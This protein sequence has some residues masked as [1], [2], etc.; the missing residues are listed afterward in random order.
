VALLLLVAGALFALLYV[1]NAA[2]RTIRR[3]E[4]IGF[5]DTLLAFLTTLILLAALVANALED[6]GLPFVEQGVV[7]IALV[8]LL[9][10]LLIAI[11][12]LR[13]PQRLRQS[14]GVFGM[15]AALLVLLSTLTVPLVSTYFELSVEIGIATPTRV[16]S[17][18]AAGAPS[19]TPS[20]Q[21]R[22]LSVFNTVVQI[23]SEE[24]GLNAETIIARLEA[25]ETIAGLVQDS[26]GDLDTV[27]DRITA[28][29]SEQIR[30]LQAEA[31]MGRVQAALALSQMEFIVRLGVNQRLDGERFDRLFS[32]QASPEADMETVTPVRTVTP[33]SPAA[34]PSATRTPTL[35][36]TATATDTPLPTST[37]APSATPTALPNCQLVMNYNVNLRAAPDFGAEVLL[38]I[39]Y[40]TNVNASGRTEDAAWWLVSYNGNTGWVSSDYVAAGGAC[41]N[42]PVR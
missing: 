26:G 14:R 15:G 8:A 1:L 28:T 6:T 22:A 5:L 30:Q 4:R 32:A 29:L 27:I 10:S 18:A 37:R 19:A 38:T 34:S 41:L 9:L 25:G 39:P 31:R 16:P 42:L 17:T 23:V 24:T 3:T 13:R 7:I 12:E 36:D 21:Q 35:T 2:I 40:N 20:G 33:V 11:A